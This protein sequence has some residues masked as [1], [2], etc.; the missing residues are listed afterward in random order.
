MET[1]VHVKRYM[2]HG[3]QENRDLIDIQAGA[4]EDEDALLI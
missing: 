1:H 2:V 3:A 4:C